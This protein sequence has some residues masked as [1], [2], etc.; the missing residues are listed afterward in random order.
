M[1]T[2]TNT[3]RLSHCNLPDWQTLKLTLSSLIVFNFYLNAFYN[4]KCGHP[5]LIEILNHGLIPMF[6]FIAAYTSKGISWHNWCDKLVPEVIIYVTFQT[7]SAI[8]LYS[9]GQL[10]IR[11][12]LLFPQNG[13]WFFLAIPVWQ[14]VFLSLPSFMKCR[15]NTTL[16]VFLFSIIISFFS[17]HY[18]T[19]KTGF[20]SILKYFPFFVMAYFIDD[21]KI[22]EIRKKPLLTIT[23]TVITTAICIYILTTKEFALINNTVIV[24]L[25]HGF[26]I[27]LLSLLASIS[28]SVSIICI[29]LST[30]RFITIA[31]NAL[32][33]YLIHP[34]ICFY[35]L[36]LLNGLKI[37]AGLPL[38]TLLTLLTIILALLFAKNPIIHWFLSPG[39]KR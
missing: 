5:I 8:M 29:S 38:I 24:S 20:Y 31:N 30:K 9:E 26:F 39:I 6:V 37:D 2:E 7:V 23:I 28:I 17:I 32:G 19:D 10:T 13:V 14:S 36:I 34:I 21:K 35:F 15:I 3:I 16:I 27:Y 4:I 12:Y 1:S 18:L 33:V 25:H 22:L 11:E